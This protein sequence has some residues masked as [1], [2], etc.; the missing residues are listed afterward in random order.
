[1][2]TSKRI[3]SSR[4]G[5]TL[6]ELLVVIAIIA[7]LI[8]LL[9]PAVQKVR[10]A[11]GR[12]QCQNNIRQLGIGLHAFHDV[13]KSLPKAGKRVNMLSWHVFILPHIEQ[14]QLYKQFDFSAGAYNGG[15]DKAGPNKNIHALNLIPT[16]QCPSTDAVKMLQYSPHVVNV[17]EIVTTPS[18]AQEV[19][20]TTHYYGV[21]GPKGTNPA[22]GQPY[23]ADPGATYGGFARQG[24]FFP[25]TSASGSASGPPLGCKM[26]H[27]IDG[28]SNTLM[29]GEMSWSS[30]TTGT[31][32]RSWVRGCDGAPVCASARNV[33]NGINNFQTSM[34][35][36]MAFG[37]MHPSGT[38]FLLADASARFVHQSI[39]MGTYY[40]LASR[41][42][43]ET[44]SEN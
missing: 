25:D 13:W 37:S 8:A 9:V 28:T 14:E 21:L 44:I 3:F 29:V 23:L 42:G 19:P 20:Y 22:D 18:G 36:D 24:V 4:P 34:F 33:A 16:F 35:M 6:I 26:A 1:M 40:S 32:Y 7:I 31:R 43:G 15:I 10:E 5:F 27:I 2:I 12:T 30:F 41:D 17:N 38:N 39:G 11:A